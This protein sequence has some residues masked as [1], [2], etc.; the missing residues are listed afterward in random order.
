MIWGYPH[1]LETFIFID[2]LGD[3][4]WV[5]TPKNG[6]I[7]S[8]PP[9]MGVCANKNGA[10]HG[11]P[12]GHGGQGD[13]TPTMGTESQNG[14]ILE[15]FTWP[16][17]LWNAISMVLHQPFNLDFGD[18]VIIRMTR[19][20]ACWEGSCFDITWFFQGFQRYKLHYLGMDY[21]SWRFMMDLDPWYHIL[22]WWTHMNTSHTNYFGVRVPRFDP[23]THSHIDPYIKKQIIL[24]NICLNKYVWT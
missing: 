15:C 20:E 19:S 10:R 22:E 9:I 7:G 5:N 17:Q 23:L 16:S 3:Q 4:R 8:W 24:Y 12:T 21:D 13:Q 14:S 11:I 6:E 1:G 2:F 18:L